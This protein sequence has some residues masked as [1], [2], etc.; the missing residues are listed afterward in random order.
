M[1]SGFELLAGVVG[2]WVYPAAGPIGKVFDGKSGWRASRSG[3]GLPDRS[4]E[5]GID[6]YM[7]APEMPAGDWLNWAPYE[8]V[9]VRRQ[10]TGGCSV[11]CGLVGEQ[12]DLR[13]GVAQRGPSPSRH[14]LE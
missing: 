1:T 2:L 12:V 7:C 9:E 3:V 8:I 10:C 13:L 14:N 5:T 6:I 11:A 4:R